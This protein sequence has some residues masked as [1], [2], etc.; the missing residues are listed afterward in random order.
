[1]RSPFTRTFR[2]FELLFRGTGTGPAMQPREL[3]GFVQ[4]TFDVLGPRPGEFRFRTNTSNFEATGATGSFDIGGPD[5]GRIQVVMALV[6]GHNA[7]ASR[8]IQMRVRRDGNTPNVWG[9][10]DEASVNI[11]R[12]A[13]VA[14]DG[15]S[16]I[17]VPT[18]IPFG[19]YIT[20][21]FSG[22]NAGEDFG[23]SLYY[24]DAPGELVALT[25]LVQLLTPT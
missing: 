23:A 14:T 8:N 9:C 3:E 25:N 6:V 10:W 17:A 7:G 22:A 5:S 24:F 21:S 18:T 12:W 19:N 13:A 4:P 11:S 2:A 15:A 20:I 1:M 16:R